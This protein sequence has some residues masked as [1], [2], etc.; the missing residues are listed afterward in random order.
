M[1]KTTKSITLNGTSA[2]GESQVAILNATINTEDVGNN[3]YV[4]TILNK[5]LYNQNKSEVRKD[6]AEF[7]ELVYEVQDAQEAHE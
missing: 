2:I 3:N 7:K 6:I 1:L 5:D 4:E